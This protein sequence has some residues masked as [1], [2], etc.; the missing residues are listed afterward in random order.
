MK[1]INA[2]RERVVLKDGS[3]YVCYTVHL[4]GVD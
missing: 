1:F 2:F 4:T 3:E